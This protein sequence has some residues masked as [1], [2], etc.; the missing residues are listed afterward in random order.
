MD[1]KINEKKMEKS[2]NNIAAIL[3][4]LLI[5]IGGAVLFGVVYATGIFSIWVTFL[6]TFGAMFVYKRFKKDGNRGMV[7]FILFLSV[8][9]NLIA[10]VLGL[11]IAAMIQYPGNN[12]GYLL[13]ASCEVLFTQL[14]WQ[15][16]LC[17][18]FTTGGVLLAFTVI[19]TREKKQT[20]S[21]PNVVIPV[22]QINQPTNQPKSADESLAAKMVDDIREYVHMLKEKLIE[23][24]EFLKLITDYREKIIIP[25]TDEQKMKIILLYAKP[26]EDEYREAARK[27]LVK[28]L[29]N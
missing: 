3:L 2:A 29:A 17:I 16:L 1:K 7:L 26:Y 5:I 14:I 27:I 21:N 13:G 11:A 12:F 28:I 23:K 20:L 19:K 24:E 8:L 4:S 15:P 22:S 6:P 9:F 18:L 10:M 25:M